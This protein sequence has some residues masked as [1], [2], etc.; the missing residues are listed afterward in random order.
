MTDFSKSTILKFF[1]TEGEKLIIVALLSFESDVS[2]EFS[3]VQSLIGLVCRFIFQPAEEAAYLVFAADPNPDLNSLRKWLSAMLAI[4]TCAAMFAV[5]SG[6]KF[7]IIFYSNKWATESASQM[8]VASCTSLIFLAL[9]GISE[10]YAF[11]KGD[12]E[13]LK[14][15]RRLMMVNSVLYIGISYKMAET[16]GIAGLVYA[17]CINM[18]IRGASCLYWSMPADKS[19]LAFTASLL[20][21]KVFVGLTLLGLSAIVS[22]NHFILPYLLA[23]RNLI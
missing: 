4:G 1:L 22:I 10:A 7:L 16:I 2:A 14:K 8:L 9:N 21:H 18:L 5:V 15:V 12:K 19:T 23:S 11:A 20:T 6:S 13:V 3:L 17:N